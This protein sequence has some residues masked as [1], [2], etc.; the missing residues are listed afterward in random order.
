M[1][2]RHIRKNKFVT[3]FFIF[4]KI[5]GEKTLLTVPVPSILK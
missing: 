4:M 5:L 1:S 3:I 2:Q